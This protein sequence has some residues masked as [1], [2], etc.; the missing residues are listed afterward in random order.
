MR[1]FYVTLLLL[2]LATTVTQNALGFVEFHK[3]WVK[4]YI[5]EDDDSEEMDEY[6]S[7]VAKGKNRCLV[8]HQGK[9]KKNHNVYGKHFVGELTKEDKKDEDKINEVLERVGEMKVDAD[10]DDSMTYNE[11]IEKKEF[12]GGDL[13]DLQEEPEEDDDE[14]DDEDN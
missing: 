1:Q 4:M 13:E 6:K 5:D 8:C 3:A 7:M 14:D 10:D 9:K 12:P 11:V 2:F